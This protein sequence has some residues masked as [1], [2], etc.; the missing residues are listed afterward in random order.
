MDFSLN[1]EQIAMKKMARE[2]TDKE[3]VPYADK[4]DE[5]HYFPVEVVRKMGELGFYGAPMPEKYGGT[6]IGFL[7]QTLLCEEVSRGSASIRVAFNTQCLGTALS[8]LRHGTEE[9]KQKWIPPLLSGEKIGCFAITEPNSGSDVMSLKAHVKPDGEGWILNGGKMWISFASRADVAIVYAYNDKSAGSRGLSAFVVDM[10][11]DGI[12]TSDLDKMGTRSSPTSEISF[13]EVK[14]PKEALLGNLGDGAKIVFGSLNQ[15]R[16]CCAAG[17][18][19][20]AQACL[21]AAVLYCTEREQFGKQVGTFQMN[22]ALVAEMAADLESARWLLYRAA[23]QKDQGQL[24]NIME[25]SYAKYVAG[26][27]ATTCADKAMRILGSY[28]YSTEYPVARYYRDAILY[29]IVEGTTNIQK[30]I[31]AND[32]LGYRKANR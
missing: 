27:A 20:L 12:S 26:M 10:H 25:M 16:L 32:L 23:W 28:G 17:G 21:D 22:Q 15:T 6:D 5:E 13:D 31:I 30:M 29:Q 4:W 8:I 1:D 11:S 14:L 24:G 3:I 2:F 19:G 9:Q 18:V 7:A